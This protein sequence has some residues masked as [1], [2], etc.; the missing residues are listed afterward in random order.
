MVDYRNTKSY[1]A[2]I[3]QDAQPYQVFRCAAENVKDYDRG[4]FC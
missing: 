2:G 3:W 4:N 1:T